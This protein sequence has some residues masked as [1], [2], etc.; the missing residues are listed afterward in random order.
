MNCQAVIDILGSDDVAKQV[1]PKD[2]VKGTIPGK[3]GVR[4][5]KEAPTDKAE[6]SEYNL[7]K[8]VMEK[9]ITNPGQPYNVKH[10]VKKVKNLITPKYMRPSTSNITP[11]TVTP[12]TTPVVTKAAENI[13]EAT[14]IVDKVKETEKAI[15]KV[16]ETEKAIDTVKPKRKPR[17]KVKSKSKA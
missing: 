6:L 3:E 1:I 2:I 8:K 16:K 7:A 15:D 11:T 4:T 12:E 13:P 10:A 17:S 14:K 5:L 9:N